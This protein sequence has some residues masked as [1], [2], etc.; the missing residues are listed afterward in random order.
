M[1]FTG[2]EL[3]QAL[4]L[5]NVTVGLADRLGDKAIVSRHPIQHILQCNRLDERCLGWDG[6]VSECFGEVQARGVIGRIERRIEAD[7]F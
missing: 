4:G 1:E 3:R 2:R 7:S 5:A 6:V